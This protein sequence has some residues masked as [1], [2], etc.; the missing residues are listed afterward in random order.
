MDNRLVLLGRAGAALVAALSFAAVVPC[1]AAEAVPA[2][3]PAPDL[4][5]AG[6][7]HKE[8]GLDTRPNASDGVRTGS[9]QERRAFLEARR[10][11]AQE[12]NG[13]APK[14]AAAPAP[15]RTVESA[16]P[17]PPAAID[18]AFKL[19]PLLSGP[20]YGGERWVSPAVYS[21]AAHAASEITVEARAM[22]V[23]AKGEPLPIH[24]E[25]R[26]SDASVVQLSQGDGNAVRITVRGGAPTRVTVAAAGLSQ[27]FMVSSKSIG[28]AMQVQIAR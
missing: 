17:G 3:E 27:V 12:R 9:Y 14:K 2:Q 5:P 1:I 23:D 11:A 25:W 21:S 20:T 22:A 6:R 15:A 26:T 16:T 10:R 28:N 19:D 13:V 24:P 18:I 8:L 7:I 4:S